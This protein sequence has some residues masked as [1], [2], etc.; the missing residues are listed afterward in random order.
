M[1]KA[2]DVSGRW[3]SATNALRGH[4]Y[5]CP[6]CRDS[7]TVIKGSPHK[8]DHFRH[9]P[10]STCS[11]GA[12]ETSEHAEKKLEIFMELQT[13]LGKNNVEMEYRLPD[14]QEPDIYFETE[15]QGVAVEIQHSHI[16]D[17]DLVERTASYSDKQVAS[18]W[19]PDNIKRYLNTVDLFG[20][21][22]LPYIPQWMHRIAELTD[23][24]A[25]DHYTDLASHPGEVVSIQLQLK[26]RKKQDAQGKWV[27]DYYWPTRSCLLYAGN[28]RTDHNDSGHRL[29]KWIPEAIG[30]ESLVSTRAKRQQVRREII[31]TAGGVVDCNRAPSVL[32]PSDRYENNPELLRDNSGKLPATSRISDYM[33]TKELLQGDYRVVLELNYNTGFLVQSKDGKWMPLDVRGVPIQW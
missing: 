13:A 31:D 1:I 30:G 24:V 11:Y 9:N 26:T 22:N 23:N 27:M 7:L 18:L 5:Y 15:G 6:K 21:T 8:I 12:G 32:Q 4:I 28:V 29:M 25:F 20:G 10:D 14:G 17:A 3:V 16:S 33:A 19:M 2:H